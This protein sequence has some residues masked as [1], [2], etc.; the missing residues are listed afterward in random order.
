[1]TQA[2]KRG[3]STERTISGGL[4]RSLG[5]FNLGN[6]LELRPD[7][8]ADLDELLEAQTAGL[9]PPPTHPGLL[10]RVPRLRR[11]PAP[12]ADGVLAACA[13]SSRHTRT[14]LEA[15]PARRADKRTGRLDRHRRPSPGRV[16]RIAPCTP[17]PIAGKPRSVSESL[18]SIAHVTLPSTVCEEPPNRR[19]AAS[20]CFQTDRELE[21]FANVATGGDDIPD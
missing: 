10:Q 6:G 20:L 14:Q 21:P 13:P 7:H 19:L 3:S 4:V 8:G 9:Q 2:A 15:G 11:H 5:G 18:G 16:Q 1:M 12:P 17:R